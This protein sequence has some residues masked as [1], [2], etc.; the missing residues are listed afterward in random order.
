MAEILYRC[1]LCNYFITKSKKEIARHEKMPIKEGSIDGLII[2]DMGTYSV[3]KKLN[4]LDDTHARLYVRDNFN[5]PV[6]KYWKVDKKP[7]HS[8]TSERG[9][10]KQLQETKKL[11]F[12]KELSEEEFLKITSIIR[13][14]NPVYYKNT[15]FVREI[16][17]YLL[18]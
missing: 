3:Y 2:K 8:G 6:N 4:K 17:A 13:K 1:E 7:T 16:P 11:N 12:L 10:I 14:K 18:K 5:P 9:F 15:N